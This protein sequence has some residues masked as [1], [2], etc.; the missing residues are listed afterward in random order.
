MG[1]L[2][3]QRTSLHSADEV[4]GENGAPA[5]LRW[6]L[7]ICAQGSHTGDDIDSL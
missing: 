1:C 5:L 7:S 3:R 2:L 4:P 6:S